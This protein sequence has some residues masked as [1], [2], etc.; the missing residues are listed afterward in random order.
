MTPR[1]EPYPPARGL[2]DCGLFLEAPASTVPVFLNAG[3]AGANA[4]AAQLGPFPQAALELG[5]AGEGGEPDDVVPQP[6][7]LRV[8]GQPAD[9]R[10]EE[11]GSP[12]AGRSG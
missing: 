6:D 5:E 8:T 3:L 7:R 4:E 2:A 9:D 10:P 1:P 12:P 11:G